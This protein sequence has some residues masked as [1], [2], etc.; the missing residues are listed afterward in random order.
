MSAQGPNYAWSIYI[1]KGRAFLP[2]VARTE[3]GFLL[4]M[5]P[6]C[7]APFNDFESFT[8]AIA[9][10]IATGNPRIPTPGRDE[11]TK[12]VVL[13]VAGIRSWKAFQRSG[14]CFTI[15]RMP[16]EDR[17]YETGRDE[18]GRWVDDPALTQTLPANSTAAE[19]ARRIMER[20]TE[21]GDLA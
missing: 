13:R 2:I 6:V 12:P 14:A 4:D 18:N 1:Y 7:A 16:T 15:C 11:F 10:A 21:R 19:I 5:E 3:A 8:A 9:A 17:L 20:V